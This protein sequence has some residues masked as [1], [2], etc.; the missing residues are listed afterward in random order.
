MQ[1]PCDLLRLSSTN[2]KTGN[3]SYHLPTAN[4]MNHS[5]IYGLRCLSLPFISSYM[6]R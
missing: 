5:Y 6:T 4:N 3:K 2:K 1:K